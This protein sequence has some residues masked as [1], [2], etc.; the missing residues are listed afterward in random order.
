V[1]SERLRPI[2]IGGVLGALI[3]VC[4]IASAGST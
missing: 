3:G 1:H 2:Q 4:L